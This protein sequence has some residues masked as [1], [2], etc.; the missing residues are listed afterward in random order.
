MPV[1][2][3]SVER[4]LLTVPGQYRGPGGA[5]AVL[6]DGELV[7]QHVWGFA[8][9][10]RRIPMTPA[11]LFPICSTTK[12]MF[13]QAILDLERNPPPALG[14]NVRQ[15]LTAA[16]TALL[17]PDLFPGP[18]GMTIDNLWDMRSGLRDYWALCTLWGAAPESR[19]TIGAHS[20]PTLARL[21]TPHF[22]PAAAMSYS[23][24][25]YHVLGRAVEAVTRDTVGALLAARVFAPAGMATARVVA[26]TATPLLPGR[27]VGHEGNDDD[28]GFFA[29]ARN[30]IEWAGD[31]GAVASLEDM[32]AYERHFD[33]LWRDDVD[34]YRRLAGD[35]GRYV[36]GAKARYRLG[37]SHVAL[38]EA[39]TPTVGHGGALRGF[40]VHRRYVPEKRLSVVVLFNHE[41]SA[42]GCA[43]RLIEELLGLSSVPA[44]CGVETEAA[45][46]ERQQPAPEW[47]GVFLD[48]ETQLAVVVRP[49]GDGG[50]VSILWAGDDFRVPLGDHP[51]N[52]R[53][54]DVIASVDGDSLHVQCLVDNVKIEAKRVVK[55]DGDLAGSAFSGDFRCEELDSTLHCT[56]QGDLLYGAFDGFLGE[57]PPHLMRHVGGD[58]W[59]L[60]DPRGMDAPA[61]G[62]WT[63]VFRR[64]DQGNVIGLTIG[65]WLARKLEYVKV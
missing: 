41:A 54:R 53:S 5:I 46:V 15:K 23:N 61:P 30:A 42:E 10:D 44:A 6:H 51:R 3:E 40:R 7:G 63:V 60:A 58:V 9:L 49:G 52:A 65:C 29:P 33:R 62:N 56:G 38:G 35:P 57:G 39:K 16:I 8:D 12:Q 48:A 19:Y 36:D 11:T 22:A 4:I 55:R 2:R 17:G 34:E 59:F 26:D 13:C 31:A 32:V 18:D 21:Q 24:T 50:E 20:Q 25:N 1:T 45:V 28:R 37:L 43:A 27:C 14:G 47:F 64:D